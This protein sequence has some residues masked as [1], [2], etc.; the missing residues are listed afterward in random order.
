MIAF[1]R[2]YR[3]SLIISVFLIF[4]IGIFVGL[5]G[6]FFTGADTTEAVAMVGG[7]KL[8]YMDFRV[9][10]NQYIDAMRSQGKELKQDDVNRLKQE[11]LRDMIVSEILAQQA[12]KMGL[13]VS[14]AELALTIQNSPAFQ[15]D[16][17]FHQ[18]LYFQIVR[19]VYKSTPESY[20]KFQRR[21]MLSAK[22]KTLLLRGAKVVPSEV[23]GEYLRGGGSIVEFEKEKGEFTQQ[24]Q[25][26]RALDAINFFLRQLS[27][28]VEIRSYLDQRERGT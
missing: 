20:E 11:M 14:D 16:G 5:G 27:T 15:R 6:Y 9:R 12:E 4:L 17:R 24:L 7:T 26:R 13:R 28:Q 3:Q 8:K 18:G 19:S 2:R 1:L 23:R 25:Q 21:A 10:I 22:L